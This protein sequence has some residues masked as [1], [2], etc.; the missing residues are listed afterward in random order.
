M[1]T[2]YYNVPPCQ[3]AHSMLRDVELCTISDAESCYSTWIFMLLLVRLFSIWEKGAG[4]GCSIP[5]L[6]HFSK[7][8]FTLNKLRGWLSIN[9]YTLMSWSEKRATVKI[10]DNSNVGCRVKVTSN[11]RGE[12]CDVFHCINFTNWAS[13]LN[14]REG[15]VSNL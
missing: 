15:F 7:S 12:C 4:V 5:P 13:F 2:T 11:T 8:E 14:K 6:L 9:H 1:L 10:L 3:T